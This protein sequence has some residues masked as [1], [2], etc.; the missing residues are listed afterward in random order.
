MHTTR[1]RGSVAQA[2]TRA[3]RTRR[4]ADHRLAG[5][6]VADDRRAGADG[7]PRADAPAGRDA[8]ADADERALTDGDVAGEGDPRGDVGEGAD[9]AAVVDGRVRVDDDAAFEVGDGIDDRTGH[10]EHAV[11][12]TCAS[13]RRRQ[14]G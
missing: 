14:P 6:D 10:H 2:V 1:T 8:G 13:A 3:K 4:D 7:G 11:V 9:P 5:R 12:D